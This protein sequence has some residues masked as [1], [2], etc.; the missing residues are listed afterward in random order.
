MGKVIGD[1]YTGHG[2]YV[3]IVRH[4][5]FN[6]IKHS[7]RYPI[8]MTYLELDSLDLLLEQKWWFGTRP[9]CWVRFRFQDYLNGD[10]VTYPTT[11][12]ELK[13]AVLEKLTQL[14]GMDMSAITRVNMLGHLRYGGLYFS[15]LNLYYCFNEHNELCWVLAE[16]SNTPWNQRHYYA[17]PIL[18]KSEGDK[19]QKPSQ[20]FTVEHL[21]AFHVSP[22]NPMEQRYSWL[23]NQPQTVLSVH[24]ET[25]TLT[26]DKHQ[27]SRYLNS[28]PEQ[29]RSI[30]VFDATMKLKYQPFTGHRLGKQLIIT[31]IM[32]I[33]V[34][35][36]IYWQALKLWIKKAPFYNHPTRS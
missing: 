15:P 3:G 28:C 22:F 6:P 32:T 23:L 9:W 29:T 33:K 27:T 11:G 25:L 21:K 20:R 10:N 13:Q 36:G 1:D 12:K 34:I 26:D 30:K 16:V 24:L 7:F 8:F 2:L 18:T 35:I 17:L 14:T 4:R 19:S 5:R 31:P